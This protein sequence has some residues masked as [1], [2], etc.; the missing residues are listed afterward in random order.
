MN[1]Y[2]VKITFNDGT[3]A[4]DL[5]HASQLDDPAEGNKDVFIDGNRGDGS[6][7][8]PG[9]KKSQDIMIGGWLFDPTG[10]VGLTTLIEALKAAVTTSAA[11]LTYQYYS[12]GTWQPIWEYT[13]CRVG[14]IK[15]EGSSLRTDS[16]SYSI[17]FRVLAY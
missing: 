16:I 14:E 10:F 1:S 5:P 8:I 4:Y 6:I 9:G 13:V 2:S 11:T 17:V 12:S 15:L 3:G 7:R